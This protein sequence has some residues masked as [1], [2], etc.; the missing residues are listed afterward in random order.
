APGIVNVVV[1]VAK[2]SRK[3]YRYHRKRRAFVVDYR[4]MV[5]SPTEYGWIPETWTAGGKRLNALVLVRKPTWAG[6]ACEIRPIGA[7]KRRDGDHQIIGVVLGEPKFDDIRDIGD[8]D[9]TTIKRIVQFFE[10]FFPLE[11][12]MNRE[13]TLAFLKES[14]NLY[15]ER[16]ARQEPMHDREEDDHDE[17]D[18]P[19]EFE[20]DEEDDEEDAHHDD[21][22]EPPQNPVETSVVTVEST[23][24]EAARPSP[25][26]SEGTPQDDDAHDPDR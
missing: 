10:P 2:G 26:T 13:D 8:L 1:E 12:W 5:P 23:P 9:K 3:R 19:Q 16:A 7:V 4:L 18:F 15:R 6:N 21:A 22:P 20:S 25:E 14:R 11:G 17:R 24:S